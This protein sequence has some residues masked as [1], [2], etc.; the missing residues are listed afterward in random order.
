MIEALKTAF[1]D[2][3]DWDQA[4]EPGEGVGHTLLPGSDPGALSL[5]HQ[6]QNQSLLP[7]RHVLNTS[8]F[9]KKGLH[10][11]AVNSICIFKTV[12][13]SGYK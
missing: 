6:D 12:L 9:T 2:L 8:T 3:H 1:Q 7:A 5:A 4:P 13:W 10:L 11:K